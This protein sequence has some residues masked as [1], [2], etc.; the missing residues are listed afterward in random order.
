MPKISALPPLTSPDGDDESPIVDDSATT[1]KKLTLTGLKEWLQTVVGW[2]TASMISGLD[3]SLLTTDSNPYKFRAYRSSAWT[4]TNGAAAKLQC[5]T[6]NF[7]TN[8]NYD[9]TTNYRYTAPVAGFYQFNAAITAAFDVGDIYRIYLY[10]NGAVVSS[11]N[12]IVVSSTFSQTL[13]VSDFI[14]LSAGDYVE[15][16][17][18]NGAAAGVAGSTGV[19]NTFFGG[20]LVSRT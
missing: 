8:S 9:A 19:A 18:V 6:E 20:F 14:Q 15:V 5:N 11:G 13:T 3:K 7:D 2:I 10:K 16:Y 12:A 1:T 17:Y 4:M